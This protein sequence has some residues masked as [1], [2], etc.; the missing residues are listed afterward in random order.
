MALF[1]AA[2]TNATAS[3]TAGAKSSL[4]L[5][6]F[7]NRKMKVNELSQIGTGNTSAAAAYFEHQII[8]ATGIG[9]GAITA[10]VPVKLEADSASSVC[11]ATQSLATSDPTIGATGTQWLNLG[12]NVYG[13]IYRWVARPNGE[14]VLRNI[15]ATGVGA[16]GTLVCWN[17]LASTTA[18]YS[19]HTVWDEL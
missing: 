7:T 3:I 16:A 6:A 8:P 5:T 2:R 13:G 19:L 15:A 9:S 11:F 12:C 4:A 10:I 1:S 18:V 17:I 14:I